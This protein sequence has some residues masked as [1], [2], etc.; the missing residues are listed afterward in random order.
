VGEQV[1]VRD[2]VPADGALG[3]R[4]GVDPVLRFA[5]PIDRVSLNDVSVTLS[6]AFTGTPVAAEARMSLTP[7]PS[8]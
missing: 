4:P 3:V 7:T 8:S 1:W 6:D 5:R 2:T